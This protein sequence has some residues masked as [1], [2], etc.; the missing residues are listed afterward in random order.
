MEILRFAKWWW[1]KLDTSSR[2]LFLVFTLFASLILAGV[3][4]GPKGILA[5]LATILLI[6]ISILI[7]VI[8]KRIRK[9]Y[10]EYKFERE[11]EADRIVNRLKGV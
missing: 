3:L 4:F 8:Q 5:V 7:Y 10:Q 2:A 11:Q 9:R 1:A 6:L